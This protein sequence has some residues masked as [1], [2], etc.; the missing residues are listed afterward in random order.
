M[1]DYGH[2]IRFGTFISPTNSSPQTPV[3][4]AVLSEQLGYDLVTFQDHPYQPGFLDT[5]TLLTW[6]AARTERIEISGNVL[7]LPLRP[8]AV[9]ARAAASLDLLSEGRFAMGI[10]AGGFWDAIESMGGPRRTPGEA[11]DALS[12]AIDVMRGLWD[13]GERGMLR[14]DGEH[15]SVKGAKR[16]PKPAHEIP[17]WLGAYKPRMLRMIG[18][19]ADGWLPSLP[20]LKGHDLA[21]GN[22]TIDKAAAAAGR[23]PAEIVRLLNIGPPPGSAAEWRDQLLPFALEDGISTFILMGDD[24]GLL[25][26]FAEEV[27]PQLRQAVADA[28]RTAGTSTAPRRSS[29]ALAKRRPGIEYDAVPESLAATAVEPGDFRYSDV[30][31]T[32]LRGGSPGL[33]LPVQDSEQVAEALAY[34]RRHAVPLGIR[35]GGHG[36]SGRST[37]DGGI[38]IDLGGL[39]TVEILDEAQRLVRV[40]AGARWQ[41]VARTLD[42]L[43]WAISSGDYGGVGVGGLATAG[44]IGFMNREHGLTIDHVRA[45]ELVLADGSQVRASADENADLYWA[46]RGAGANFGIATAFELQADEVGD[47]GWANLYFDATDTAG[48]LRRWGEFAEQAPRDTTSFLVMGPPRGGQ[49]VGWALTMVDRSDPDTIIERLQ[50]MIELGPLLQQQVQLTSYAAVIANAADGPHQGWGEP[51]ARAGLLDAMTP[52]FAADAAELLLSGDVHFFQIRAMGGAVADVAPDATPFFHRSAQHAVNGMSGH[53]DRLDTHWSALRP[54]FNGLYL[55]FETDQSP[56]RLVEAFGANLPRLRELKAT[57]DP[58]N[59]FRD[60]FPLG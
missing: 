55:S 14:V 39:N 34:A 54:H 46:M 58:D 2:P 24:P 11:V 6:V 43:G 18:R 9:L 38:V 29:V 27:A 15:Y 48:F 20:Y 50:P 51:H 12:E 22:A 25:A 13:A 17:I 30:R 49:V 4:L 10:G 37:N 40:G 8:P 60:N 7:N 32:Y 41:D 28:R 53:R 44:G 42:P 3:E 31:S 26:T 19:K 1:P 56:E 45:V 5:W 33:V 52:E 21:E 35:S 23:D 57:W 59:V 16:G 36:M 47:V